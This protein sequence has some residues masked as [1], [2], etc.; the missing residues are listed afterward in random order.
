MQVPAFVAE[1]SRTQDQ[2]R[3]LVLA[4]DSA[5]EVSYALVRGSGGRLGDAE[6]AAA[7]GTDDR[8]STVVARLVAGSGADQADQLGGFAVRYVLVRDGSPREMSRVLDSTPGLTRLSQQDGSALWRV[9]R[10]VSRAAVVAKDG[11]GEPLPVAAGPVELHTELPAA[12]PDA[13]C[14]SPTPPTRAGPPP[15]TANRWSGSPS[16]TGRRASPSPRAAAASTSPSR[17][18][19]P[20]PRG[21]GRRASSASSWSSSPCPAAAAPST[22]TCRTSPRPF[23]PSPSRARAAAPA[24]CAP[25]P[26]RRPRPPPRRPDPRRTSRNSASPPP[27][28]PTP[29]GPPPSPTSPPAPAGRLRPVRLSEPGLRPVPAG[30]PTPARLR[31]ERLR[32]VP[33][34]APAP[35]PVPAGRLAAGAAGAAGLS[36]VRAAAAA[37]LRPGPGGAGVRAVR[38]AAPRPRP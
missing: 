14:A 22:T 7:A 25:R 2:A 30:L 34:A 24:G 27:T 13:Y 28:S 21:S 17:T 37:G 26:R 5:A 10:Q 38:A 15:S 36:R 6:L 11:S 32:P 19:S 4:G 31:P 35:G 29:P 3:T 1:E 9:D 8:L 33:A 20:T 12:R 18:P 23:P 16:T